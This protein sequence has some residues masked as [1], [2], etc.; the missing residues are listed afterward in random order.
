[1]KLFSSLILGVAIL[2]GAVLFAAPA[3]VPT[4][5]SCHCEKCN[6]TVESNCGCF[7][8]AGCKCADRSCSCGEQCQCGCDCKCND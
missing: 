2:S 6:C 7:S 3:K 5:N 1:M 4:K 8:K